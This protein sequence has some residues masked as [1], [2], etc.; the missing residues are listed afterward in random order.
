MK[1]LLSLTFLVAFTVQ[2]EE[3]LFHHHQ[4]LNDLMELNCKMVCDDQE[5]EIKNKFEAENVKKESESLIKKI[6]PDKMKDLKIVSEM[7]GDR[8]MLMEQAQRLENSISDEFWKDE[9]ENKIL[10]KDFKKSQYST[11]LANGLEDVIYTSKDQVKSLKVENKRIVVTQKVSDQEK[12][13]LMKDF[14]GPLDNE[15]ILGIAFKTYTDIYGKETSHTVQLQTSG[16][17]WEE[18]AL[19]D[20]VKMTKASTCNTSSSDESRIVNTGRADVEDKN[21]A[22]RDPSS[23]TRS[24]TVTNK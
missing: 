21:S 11:P 7:P 14:K 2:A 4:G 6:S 3:P 17:I 9:K 10:G 15:K 22:K 12:Q 19:K 18:V 24:K 13:N 23:K 16:H 20:F 1:S 5:K 8:F